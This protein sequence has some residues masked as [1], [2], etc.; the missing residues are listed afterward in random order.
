VLGCTF[1]FGMY[2]V[3]SF[4]VFALVLSACSQTELQR[5]AAPVPAKW[6]QT[7]QSSRFNAS[8]THWRSFFTDPRLRALLEAA[9]ENNRDLR[10]AAGRVQEARAQY[11]VVRADKVPTVSLGPAT[12]TAIT[13]G[14]SAPL[15]SASYELDFWGR[16]TG[17]TE[18]A[19]FSF[20]ATE[21]AQRAVQLTL[22]ADVANAYYEILQLDE[23]IALLRATVDL[24]E[25]TAEL[26]G[27][28]RDLGAAN[29]NEYLQATVALESSR[30]SLAALGHQR[31][32]AG[33]R[34]DFLVGRSGVAQP[35]GKSIEEPGFDRLLKPGVPS[36]V[37]L[38]RP[39]VMASEQRLRAAH[40]NIGVARAA[41]FPKIVITAGFGA[42]GGG[43]SSLLAA[44]SSTLAPLVSLPALWDGGRT[45][46]GVAVAQARQEIAV[47]EYE[48]TIQQ[49]FREVADQLS[50][51]E[52]LAKQMRAAIA[53]KSAQERRLQ[54]AQGRYDGGVVAYREVID[55][56][57]DLLSAQQAVISLRRSQ[58]EAEVQLYKALGGG[59]QRVN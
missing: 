23:L 53:N 41:F 32:V 15:L 1:F 18:V 26:V 7:E 42:V 56:Q 19:R 28:G 57:Q 52:A 46:G 6:A 33:N 47:A 35:E 31:V 9:L 4:V 20:L 40:A 2:R 49:A 54:I 8:P 50:A 25:H 36:E 59:D 11:G 39:D 12:G 3:S 29:D 44:N 10:I 48:K 5:P 27:K 51:R 37:L 38:L 43:F 22:V 45:Q 17:M 58:L 30:S 14:Y 55:G 34:L 13:T 24:R 16:I 21:E